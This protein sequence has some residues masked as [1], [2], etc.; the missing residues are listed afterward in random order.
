MFDPKKLEQ[1]AKQIH[2]AMP[3]PVKE[4]GTDMESR[5]RQAIQGQLTKLDVV[6]R[7]EFD[8]Q[9]QVLLRTRQKLTELEAKLDAMETKV[10]QST[11]NQE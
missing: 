10:G 7:E 8:V 9:T 11:D 4:L 1:M 2:D 5:V 3:Q 6:S